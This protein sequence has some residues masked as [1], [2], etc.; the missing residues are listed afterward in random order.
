MWLALLLAALILLLAWDFESKRHRNVTLKRSGITGPRSLPLIGCG[1]NLLHVGSENAIDYIRNCFDKYGDTF[2]IWILNESQVY[3]KNISHFEDILSS[4]TLLD[5]G[6]LYQ[7]LRAFLSD[8]LLL[9]VFQKW[10][11]RR[12]VFSTAFHFKIL[13]H[14]VGIMDSQS[15]ILVEKLK[16]FA[17]GEHIVDTHQYVSLAALDIVTEAAMGVQVNSQC[18]PDF[19]YIKAL[20]S[21]VNI[22]TDRWLKFSQRYN[23]LFRLT[24]PILYKQLLS[25]IRIMHDFTDKVIHERR[26][27]VERSKADGTYQSICVGDADTGSKPKMALLDIL[28]Q[29]SI[30]GAPLSDADIHEEV[31]TFIFAGDDTTSS[32][33]SHALYCIA[34][35]PA[36]QARLY[37][38]LVQVLGRNRSAPVTQTQL[39][40]LKYLECVIK[41]TLRLY[42]P[43]PGFGR[44]TT[45]DL[46]IGTQTIP[47]NTSIYMVPYLAHRAAKNFP[48]P[49][50]FKP[51]RFEHDDDRL[52]FSYIPFS[53][54]PRNC[55]GQKFAMLEMKTMISK[56][57][58]YYELLPKGP[59]LKEIM[60]FVLRSAT[61]CNVALKLRMD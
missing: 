42:S 7:F 21:V 3:T 53:A 49:L 30:Q 16:P 58:R 4:T 57:L 39:M 36:V 52:T 34:R 54:G 32:A 31:D 15:A 60:N 1:L 35:H 51:E 61:G 47:A 56:V 29:S 38:E 59:E 37:A 46:Q 11:S 14:Y 50:S 18:N 44:F 8:G 45:K 43:V 26:G 27:A 55:L 17:N 2:H 9:S 22:Q 12:K 24:A 40:Q 48:D 19:P 28:L 23:W 20:K 41:E 6:Q 25:D 10:H 33:V 5:K 13:E